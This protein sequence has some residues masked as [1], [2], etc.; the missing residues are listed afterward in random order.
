M[1]AKLVDFGK[2]IEVPMRELAVELLE[3]VDDVVDALGSRREVEYLQTIVRD[4]TSADRQLRAFAAS[5][6]F[7]EVVDHVAEE[8]TAGVPVMAL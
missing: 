6:H 8:T 2:Q 1:D 4:G 3:F 5:G 7:H